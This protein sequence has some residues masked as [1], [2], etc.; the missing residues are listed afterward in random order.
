MLAQSHNWKPK[1]QGKYVVAEL[2][3]PPR[4][5]AAAKKAGLEG[6]S[7]D[8][9]QGYDL[10]DPQVQ[11]LVDEELD[12]L[13]PDLLTICPPSTHWGG[14]DHLNRMY[15]TPLEN[16]R[17]NR[18]KRQQCRYGAAQARKQVDRGGD[19]VFEHPWPSEMWGEPEIA[20]PAKKFQCQK[21]DMCAYGLKC[22]DSQLPIQKAQ[23]SSHPMTTSD[24]VCRLVQVAFLIV[25]C[26]VS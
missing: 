13:Q 14:W 21:A 11:K 9:K 19:F 20:S 8:I 5:A 15:R 7:Y 2:F 18:I 24:A 1:K 22:P 17:L 25:S 6:K 3:S 23:V 26:L 4:F 10:T 16:A 12:A